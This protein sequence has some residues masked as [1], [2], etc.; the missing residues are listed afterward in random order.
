MDEQERRVAHIEMLL[1]LGRGREAE[2][3]ASLA[4]AAEPDSAHLTHLLARSLWLQHRSAE[5]VVHARNAVR[6]DPGEVE[7]LILLAG[8]LL[9]VE[10]PA[11]AHDVALSA[12]GLDPDNWV[13]HWVLAGALLNIGGEEARR[14]AELSAHHAV[15]L[16][17]HEPDPHNMYGIA[18]WRA[19]DLK[20]AQTAFANALAIDPTH[21]GALAN[22]GQAKLD[23]GDLGEGALVLS[24]ALS[25]SPQDKELHASVGAAAATVLLHTALFTALAT[26][27]LGSLYH[28]LQ[29][30]WFASLTIGVTFAVA[31]PAI[32]ALKNL[33]P[34]SWRLMFPSRATR[35]HTRVLAFGWSLLAL[36][37][38]AWF[39]PTRVSVTVL[40]TLAPLVALAFVTRLLEPAGSNPS[41]EPGDEREGPT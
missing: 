10:Q 27:V 18:R 11:E 32:T 36:C 3:S 34:R 28:W 21:S 1:E 33:P 14:T 2:R 9:D 26:L 4:L 7:H 5:A 41:A 30:S 19:G 25:L 37:A 23:Q 16:G 39:G 13:T 17:P 40:V 22:L 6:L 8:A 31:G 35:S 15:T 38:V 29:P 20:T 12:V 24:S